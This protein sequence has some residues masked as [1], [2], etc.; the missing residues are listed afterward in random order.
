MLLPMTPE[1]R[2]AFLPLA[3]SNLAAQSAEQ[4]CLAAVPIV[5]V[6]SLQAGPGEVGALAS[7]QTLPFLLL[8]IPLGLLAD[9]VPRRGLML[10][11]EGVRVLTLLALCLLVWQDRVSLAALAL[12][13]FIGAV[14]TV[15][16]SVA[17]PAL[18]PTLVPR[19]AL[20][21]ANGRIELARS[22]AYA[23]GPA[24]AGSL[25]AWAGA[26]TAF[27]AAAALSAAAVLLMT[28]LHEPPREPLPRRHPLAEMR[29]GAA[30]VWRQGLL[31]PILLTAIVWNLAWCVLQAAY[32]PYAMTVLGL[33]AAGVG[34][35]LAAYGAG[36]VIGALAASRL[37]PALR[38]GQAVLL[39]PLVSVAA[40]FTM[41]ASTQWPWSALAGLSFFLFG[42]G[43]IIWTIS[44]TT[45]RQ[46]VTPQGL[47]GRV[48]A[49]FLTVNAGVR[50]VGSL[51]GAWVGAS[52]GAVACLWLAA[53]GFVLQALVI[54]LSPVRVLQ[55]LPAVAR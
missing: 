39:G 21:Q 54:A 48:G 33:S 23:G 47:L 19:E 8:S 52:H 27:A 36:M 28:R 25:V 24:L 55:A 43:P 31:R 14:G 37:I 44:S 13:G 15:G 51:T 40:A 35:T 34:F 50:P 20:G 45:L 16:F 32:V 10:A 4:I 3:W 18:L 30:F 1:A 53:A 11:A 38:Y 22:L 2:R 26:G 17:A 6:I 9:R 46:H 7:A 29:Q 12:L 42:V 41:V 5:A 49:I